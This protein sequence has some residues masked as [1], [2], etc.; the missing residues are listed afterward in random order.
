MVTIR[1][2][3]SG[4]VPALMVMMVDFNRGEGIPWTPAR[5][6]AP[7]RRL[8]GDPALG[9]VGL[10]EED[11][12]AIGYY[13]VTWGYDLEW[14]GRDA[15]LTELYI[16]PGARARG[17]GRALLAGAEEAARAAG[18]HALHLMVRHE[19]GPAIG[20]YDGAGY[21]TPERRFM[22]KVIG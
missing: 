5:G 13:V 10:A 17:A 20:L 9:T 15:F 4:D 19:N 11:G 8:V 12:A 18:A 21:T 3:V 2:A 16:A 1:T 14:D 6:E 7:L 22:T